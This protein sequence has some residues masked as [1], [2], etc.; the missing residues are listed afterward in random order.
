M[1]A[2]DK[3]GCSGHKQYCQLFKTKSF[4]FPQN[5]C[6][7]SKAYIFDIPQQQCT[8][9]D[10]EHPRGSTF[11]IKQCTDTYKCTD[12][13][14]ASHD[15]PIHNDGRKD[16]QDSIG[17]ES[18][19]DTSGHTLHQHACADCQIPFFH[20]HPHIR[21]PTVRECGSKSESHTCDTHSKKRFHKIKF[22]FPNTELPKEK[23]TQEIIKTCHNPALPSVRSL[24]ILSD[25]KVPPSSTFA[26]SCRYR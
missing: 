4:V 18:S 6:H 2:I 7:K 13:G 11:Q 24:S 5:H 14:I 26:G 22:Y 16:H 21:H 1:K 3:S 8:C 23:C 20:E 25:S 9:Q 17:I 10:R 12:T 15:R 19:S